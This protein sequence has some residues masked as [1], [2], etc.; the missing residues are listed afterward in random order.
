M[1]LSQ[2]AAQPQLVEI[3]LDDADTVRE[4]GEPVSFWTW[5][6]QPLDVFMRLATAQTTDPTVMIGLVNQLML[7]DQG[8]PII[9]DGHM[10]PT[11]LL[12]RAIGRL[13]ERLGN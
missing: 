7:D 11:P 2:L 6:R 1:K 12:V 13:T 4:H 8:Q 5:D 9:R 10:L 3:L